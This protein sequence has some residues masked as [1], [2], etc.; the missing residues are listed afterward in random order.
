MENN[1]NPYGVDLSTGVDIDDDPLCDPVIQ[2]LREALEI[3]ER[4]AEVSLAR[5][6]RYRAMLSTGTSASLIAESEV[7]PHSSMS[8]RVHTGSQAHTIRLQ[9]TQLLRE[10]KRPLS[11]AEILDGLLARG[12]QLKFKNPAKRISKIMWESDEFQH[13]PNGYWFSNSSPGGTDN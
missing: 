5:I 10:M 11:R 13:L 12:V 6:K 9:V 2:R 8:R 4:R 7:V 1:D 3:E